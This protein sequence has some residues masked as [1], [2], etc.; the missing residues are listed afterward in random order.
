MLELLKTAAEPL[1]REQYDPGHFTVG[2]TVLS[3]DRSA[4]LL[5][6]HRRLK[7][8]LEPGGH[9]DPGD[10]DLLAAAAREVG[11]E[12]GVT[13]LTPLTGEVFDVDVHPIP[14]GEEP[15]H[16]HFNVCFLYV[17]GQQQLTAADEVADAAWIPLDAVHRK[18]SDQAV[19]RAV[20]KVGLVL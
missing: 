18:T 1:A 19:L 5:V 20:E 17:A 12:T 13:E 9:I 2:A 10:A 7:V 15:P 3:P 6:L 11:E 16:R 4:V 14:G 8:W